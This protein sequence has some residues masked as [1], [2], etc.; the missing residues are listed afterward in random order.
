MEMRKVSLRRGRSVDGVVVLQRRAKKC[1]K[2]YN[3]RAQLLFSSLNLLFS[4]VL[5]AVVVM[6]CLKAWLN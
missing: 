3:A 2:S 1:A 6:V 5:V 4:D